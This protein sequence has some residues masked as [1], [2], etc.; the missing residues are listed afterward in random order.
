MPASGHETPALWACTV[1]SIAI[2][3]SGCIQ[4]VGCA[5]EQFSALANSSVQR[6]QSPQWLCGE[7]TAGWSRCKPRMWSR[8]T[9]SPCLRCNCKIEPTLPLLRRF[10]TALATLTQLKHADKGGRRAAAGAACGRAAGGAGRPPHHRGP[11]AARGGAGLPR[12]PLPLQLGVCGGAVSG[13]QRLRRPRRQSHRLH[14]CASAGS[15]AESLITYAK[16]ARSRGEFAFRKAKTSPHT[17]LAA[18]FSDNA[19]VHVCMWHTGLLA[20]ADSVMQ[21]DSASR[22]AAPHYLALSNAELPAMLSTER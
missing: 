20:G 1:M 13:D 6:A 22:S 3:P 19:R 18:C 10:V 8:W 15:E 12:P 5:S 7:A 11:A 2:L 17:L 4:G 16:A 9:Y 21:P 14:R